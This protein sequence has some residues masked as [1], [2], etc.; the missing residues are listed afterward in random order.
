MTVTVG[1]LGAG[2]LIGQ[3]IIKSL[4]DSPLETRL[5]GFDYFPTAVGL[6]W[7]DE[8]VILPDILAEEVAES[9]YLTALKRE[10]EARRIEVLLIGI[11]FDLP[12]LA[13]AREEIESETGCKVVVSSPEVIEIGD[14]KWATYEFLE[15]HGLP[16]PESLIDLDGLDSFVDRVGFPLIVKPRR[17][18]RSRGVVLAAN[19]TTLDSALESAAEPSIVQKAI[20]SIKEEYTAG[21]VVMDGACA[22]A[23][24]LKRDLRDGNTHRAYASPSP[25][26]EEMVREAAM[27]LQ[28]HGPANFQFRIGKDGP[29]IFE[30]NPRFSGTTVMRTM[31]GFNE[32]EA[33]VQWLVTGE[34][35]QLAYRREGVILRYWEE[36][37]ISWSEFNAMIS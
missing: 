20:G 12:R 17:G 24:V 7:T 1:I 26:L 31:L 25:E 16:R 2:S 23:I 15:K 13:G 29:V 8:S 4:R 32:V 30:I 34:K 9:T 3:G 36:Q 6:Y 5:V 21:V 27:K 11:D 10:I 33:V 35:Q 22:G 18:A 28:P 14:D 19:R 37:L